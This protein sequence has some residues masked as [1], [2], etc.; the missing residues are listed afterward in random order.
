M[1]IASWIFPNERTRQVAIAALIA[2]AMGAVTL[3]SPIDRLIWLMESRL[4]SRAVSGEIVFV[5][6]GADLTDPARPEHRMALAKRL[7]EIDRAGADRIFLDMVFD[8]PSTPEADKALGN[9]I[10]DLGQKIYLTKK[11]RSKPG[12]GD[13]VS[14]SIDTIAGNA[15]VALNRRYVDYSGFT[16]QIPYA[17]EQGGKLHQTLPVILSKV[18]G[19]PSGSFDID[20]NFDPASIPTIRLENVQSGGL[21]SR[22]DGDLTGSIEGRQVLIGR[23]MP[24]STDAVEIP[25]YTGVPSSMVQIIAAETLI[26]G[27]G[28]PIGLFALLAVFASLLYLI[29]RSAK[30]AGAR[31]ISYGVLALLPFGVVY[32]SVITGTTPQLAHTLGFLAIYAGMRSWSRR[33]KRQLLFDDKVGLKTFNA[34][35]RD[36]E[37][38]GNVR[39]TAVIVAKLHRFEEVTSTLADDTM[40]EYVQQIANRFRI[41]EHDL[42]VYTQGGK[43]LAWMAQT[44][45]R[46]MLESHLRGLRAVFAHPLQV[47][48]A[49]IDV[50]ITF[51]ADMTPEDNASR[52]IAS[53]SSTLEKTT[54][55]HEP[56]LFAEMASEG[57]RWWSISLQA[58]ID[59][60]LEQGHIYVVFQP[61][62]NVRTD[63]V[64]G[65][66]ALVRWKDPERGNIAP[67]YFIEQCENAGR[68]DHLTRHVLHEAL[69]AA[70]GY[71]E[72]NH[73]FTVSVNISATML[74]DYRVAEMVEE[75][76]EKTGYNP[77]NLVLEITETSRIADYD[78]AFDVMT[79]LRLLGIKLSIDDFGVGSASMETLLRLPFDEL[80]I[81]RAFIA[82][83]LDDQKARAICQMMIAFGK[84]TRITVVAEGVEDRECLQLLRDSGCEVVQ[85][86]HISRPLERDEFQQF[87]RVNAKN[88]SGHALHG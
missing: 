4:T 58:K 62:M 71:A 41:A 80:K 17:E 7:N 76:V 84:Q 1:N 77:R 72:A 70:K 65:A 86:Y 79:R 22:E 87:Q 16:W 67:N 75:I 28:T 42:Q 35:E 8:E 30:S 21:V 34:L 2:C 59:E 49:P 50:G 27:T 57:D 15:P 66:E 69:E 20:Y 26:R 19:T 54:E 46:E 11:V 68:M 24:Q 82:R 37:K 63:I 38:S 33:K 39:G 9:A 55:A 13:I 88:L 83:M 45:D 51:A 29:A 23:D 12:G 53:A 40:S 18:E 47:G 60:A 25:G 31:K 32:Y 74:R 78:V 85:G 36:L 10:A 5:A 44:N 52:K 43:Y 14:S 81:D 48:R 6:S 61:K 73:D 64:V 3:L 56:V